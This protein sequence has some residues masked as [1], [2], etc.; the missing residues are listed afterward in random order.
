M[1]TGQTATNSSGYYSISVAPGTYHLNVWPPWDTN[2]IDYDEPTF[3]VGASNFSKNITMTNGLKLSGTITGSAGEIIR[4]AVVVM[5]G[6]YL[7]GWGSNDTGYY[8]VN[9]P[10]GTYTLW[11]HPMFSSTSATNFTHYYEY[12]VTITGNMVKN[13]RVVTSAIPTPTPTP[14]SFKVS[15]YI[16]DSGGH[17]IAGAQ[18]SFNSPNLVPTVYTDVSG[19]YAVYAPAGVYHISVWP[20]FDSNYVYYDLQGYVVGG[21]DA[22][23]NINLLSGYKISGYITDSSG[24]PVQG[25]EVTL[26]GFATGWVSDY[27]GYYFVTVPAG[28]YKLSV[29]PS[30]GYSFPSYFEVNFTVNNDATKNIRLRTP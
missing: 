19:Y 15:G 4:R 5:D 21:S 23:K 11:A 13:L 14:T 29:V 12:N 17:G 26:N 18:V 28:T 7:A 10:A 8:F 30:S 24:T 22:V 3:V 2:Y 20:P 9:V 1:N 16:K 27:M 6:H 25:A